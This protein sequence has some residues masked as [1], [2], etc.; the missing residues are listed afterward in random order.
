MVRCLE[1]K[2]RDIVAADINFRL[3]KCEISALMLT[4]GE[5]LFDDLGTSVLV[6]KYNYAIRET[7][8]LTRTKL[9]RSLPSHLVMLIEVLN[10]LPLQA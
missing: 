10:L 8:L 5:L 9:F 7:K 6:Q 1:Y 3:K 2:T 4:S